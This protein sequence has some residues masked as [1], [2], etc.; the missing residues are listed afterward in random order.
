MTS[1]NYTSPKWQGISQAVRKAS[2]FG[3][4]AAAGGRHAML[5]KKSD[6]MPG[7]KS[8]SRAHVS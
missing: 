1:I 8:N 5:L 7:C 3:N 6:R 4:A 2:R